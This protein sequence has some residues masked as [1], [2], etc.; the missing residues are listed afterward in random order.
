MIEAIV[1]LEFVYPFQGSLPIVYDLA[2]TWGLRLI[3]SS[4][5]SGEA[6]LGIPWRKFQ[7]IFG[8]NPRIGDVEIPDGLQRHIKSITVIGI[9][10]E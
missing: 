6:E 8:H 5:M 1:S 7:K 10:V 3:K 2:S 9:N 4:M